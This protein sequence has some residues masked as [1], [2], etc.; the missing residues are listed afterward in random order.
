MQVVGASETPNLLPSG[1]GPAEHRGAGEIPPAVTVGVNGQA[2]ESP[3]LDH[4]GEAYRI[5]A[6]H[7]AG[8][9]L[10][11]HEVVAA[12]HL[13]EFASEVEGEHHFLPRAVRVAVDDPHHRPH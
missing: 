13:V 4:A 3:E 12:A 10:L 9:A 2:G 6:R 11:Q 8:A 5:E 1:V 7:D